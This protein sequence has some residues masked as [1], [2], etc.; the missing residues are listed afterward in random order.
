MICRADRGWNQQCQAGRP[1]EEPERVLLQ[2]AHPA[3][4]GAGRAGPGAHGQGP[5]DY[6]THPRGEP[7]AIRYSFNPLF[8]CLPCPME[9]GRKVFGLMDTNL[10]LNVCVGC[11]WTE[12]CQWCPPPRGRSTCSEVPCCYHL[13]SDLPASQEK[14]LW[15]NGYGG[16]SNLAD[17]QQTID[18]HGHGPLLALTL[19]HRAIIHNRWPS[20][21]PLA[22]L[23]D[24]LGYR[25]EVL[26][27][28]R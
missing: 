16:L 20:E 5:V 6:V 22:S 15:Q 2:G 11:T 18:A 4:P 14:I 7:P 12:A 21:S 28:I 1:A 23:L 13:A 8:T 3:V 9:T 24:V 26:G 27:Y 17:C 19:T 10:P 25:E